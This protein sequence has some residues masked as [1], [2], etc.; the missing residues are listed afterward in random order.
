MT[1]SRVTSLDTKRVLA[2]ADLV[3][4]DRKASVAW[5]KSPLAGC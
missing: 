1:N 5:L 3:T 4:G 2:A